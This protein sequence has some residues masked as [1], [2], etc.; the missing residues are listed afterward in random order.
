MPSAVGPAASTL[1]WV[2]CYLAEPNLTRPAACRVP[3]DMHDHNEDCS[4]RIS[5]PD[6]FADSH[7]R[8]ATGDATIRR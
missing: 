6:S 2:D 7:A 5:Q 4:V 3:R 1:C 8:R